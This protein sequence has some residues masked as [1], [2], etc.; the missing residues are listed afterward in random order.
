MVLEKKD[1]KILDTMIEE[2]ISKIPG[3]VKNIRLP[4]FQGVF[5]IANE[6]EYVYGYTHGSIIGKF[7]TYYFVVHSGKKPTGTEVDDI[8]KTIFAK[9]GEIRDAISKAR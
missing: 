5:Q 1:K 6:S 2:E 4:Q 7:E 9:S 8:G 3:L